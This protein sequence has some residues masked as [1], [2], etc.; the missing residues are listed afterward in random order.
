MTRYV[1]WLDTLG[2]YRDWVLKYYP[3]EQSQYR[4]CGVATKEMSKI[5]PEL[6]R[7]VGVYVCHYTNLKI[8]HCW[9]EDEDNNIIDPTGLQFE[10][11]GN[12]EN[13]I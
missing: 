1:N 5:F 2:V 9:M 13:N 7:I 3:T 10:Y 11:G 4:K 6:K 12:Y 8:S